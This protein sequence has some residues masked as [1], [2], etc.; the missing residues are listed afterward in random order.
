[1]DMINYMYAS[2]YIVYILVYLFPYKVIASSATTELPS[3]ITRVLSRVTWT[4]RD[5]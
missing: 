5:N 4:E 1:M 3:A 2:M